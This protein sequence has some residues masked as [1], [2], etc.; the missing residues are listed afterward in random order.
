MVCIVATCSA[1]GFM[2]QKR[3]IDRADCLERLI[4]MLDYLSSQISYVRMPV[5]EIVSQMAMQSRFASLTFLEECKE[6]LRQGEPF[7]DAWRASA[8]KQRQLLA[9]DDYERL[10]SLGST[11][12]ATDAQEQQQTIAMYT[13]MF[14]KSYEAARAE[15]A[16]RSRMYLTIGVL[17]GIGFA[18]LML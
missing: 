4:A 18:I 14:E 6:R 12:G 17:A 1:V 5:G 10:A 8:A 3:L 2:L 13:R 7:P 9:K 15:C 16:S 11:L